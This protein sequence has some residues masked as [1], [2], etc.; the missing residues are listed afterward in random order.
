MAM[1]ELVEG[2]LATVA[3]F[4]PGPDVRFPGAVTIFAISRP[5]SPM[6]P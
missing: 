3:V 5:S 6:R 4:L 2:A 1:D